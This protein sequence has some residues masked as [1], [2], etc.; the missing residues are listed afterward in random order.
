M[1]DKPT[2]SSLER[3]AA[4]PASCAIPVRVRSSS[5]AAERGSAIHGFIEDVISKHETREAALA[6]VP[7][8]W[9]GTCAALDWDAIT[10]DL[11]PAT[12]FAESAYALDYVTGRA[13]FLGRSLNRKYPPTSDEEITGT[14]DVDGDHFDGVPVVADVKTGQP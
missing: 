1:F 3:A 6:K 8:E 5:D 4:C 13:R 11:E 14:S 10:G 2:A 9:R 7:V 12:T